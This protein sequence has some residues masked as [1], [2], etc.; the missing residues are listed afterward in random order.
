MLQ[1]MLRM[2]EEGGRRRS[3][4]TVLVEMVETAPNSPRSLSVVSLNSDAKVASA[5]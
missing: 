4:P 5:V 1:V 3:L 2:E